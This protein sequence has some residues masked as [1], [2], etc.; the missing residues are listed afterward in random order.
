MQNYFKEFWGMAENE[1]LLDV[2]Q[3]AQLLKIST[4][5]VRRWV[6]NGFIPYMKIGKAIRF[7]YTDLDIWLSSKCST[8][9]KQDEVQNVKTA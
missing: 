2:R 3:V 4:S 6:L 5:T 7:S 8:S 9:K 1:V